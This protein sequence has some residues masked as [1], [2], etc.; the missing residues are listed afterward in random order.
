MRIRFRRASLSGPASGEVPAVAEPIWD[1][2]KSRLGIWNNRGGQ[3][4]WFPRLLNNMILNPGQRLAGRVSDDT[5]TNNMMLD[6]SSPGLMR[7]IDTNSDTVIATFSSAGFA[8]TAISPAPA[9]SEALPFSNKI[10]NATLAFRRVLVPA[11]AEIS[12]T[13][14]AKPYCLAPNC[15]VYK[16]TGSAGTLSVSLQ[17]SSKPDDLPVSAGL[18]V[19]SQ[20][21]PNG[22]GI[23]FLIPGYSSVAGK[24][25]NF[26]LYHKGPS[27][28]KFYLRIVTEIGGVV[29]LQSVDGANV[30]TRGNVAKL[31]PND[32][33][34]WMAVDIHCPSYNNPAYERWDFAGP[35]VNDTIQPWIFESRPMALEKQALSSLYHEF[36]AQHNDALAVASLIYN[37]PFEG[38]DIPI[39][40]YSSDDSSVFTLTKSATYFNA[41]RAP[42]NSAIV[43]VRFMSYRAPQDVEIY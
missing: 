28:L 35:Q 4:E 15:L 31:M 41:V 38:P 43:P 30:W 6:F 23:R 13:D 26:S 7:I 17:A 10:A 29:A 39:V 9:S 12:T 20:G 5:A 24:N 8:A 11:A 19:M 37:L 27:N 36:Y 34:K 14:I 42:R 18:R 40:E 32:G 1:T 22:S 25:I 16:K 21:S 33:S 2:L 3:Y